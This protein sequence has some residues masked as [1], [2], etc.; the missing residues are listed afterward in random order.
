VDIRKLEQEV[1]LL[2]NRVCYALSDPTRICILY[3]LA[4]GGRF[5][6]EI[7]ELLD[8]PQPT[9]SRHL[10]VLRERGLVHTDRQ[11]TAV[12]YSLADKRIVQALDLM[13]DIVVSQLAAEIDLAQSLRAR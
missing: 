9:I 10:R 13:R 1:E 2:H 8:A 3:V 11:G 6:N 7:A 5:V 12:C 4:E